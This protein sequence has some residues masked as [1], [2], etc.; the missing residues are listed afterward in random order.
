MIGENGEMFVGIINSSRTIFISSS[1][2]KLITLATNLP[3]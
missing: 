2:S 3:H 1:K